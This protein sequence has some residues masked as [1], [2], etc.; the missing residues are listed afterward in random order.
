[1]FVAMAIFGTVGYWIACQTA[2]TRA[3]QEYDRTY[4]A[5]RAETLPT[6]DACN[7]SLRLYRAEIA[8]PFADRRQAAESH[9]ARVERIYEIVY[10]PWS[11]WNMGIA[12]DADLARE[13]ARK[14]EL[15]DYC[16]EAR[17]LL[18]GYR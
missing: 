14:R 1:M 4:A 18:D 17:R 9:L 12:N 2:Y 3:K 13:L 11:E 15:E 7:S 10:G 8:V 5:W 16:A 6:V